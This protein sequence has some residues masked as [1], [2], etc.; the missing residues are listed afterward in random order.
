MQ[1]QSKIFVCWFAAVFSLA[2]VLLISINYWA[3]RANVFHART[4]A[5]ER[6]AAVLLSN[7]SLGMARNIDDRLVQREYVNRAEPLP[8]AISVGSSR[9]REISSSVVPAGFRFFNHG[10]NGGGMEDVVAILG[11]YMQRQRL[12]DLVIWSVDPW[13]FN[14]EFAAQ[15]W[16]SIAD[17]YEFA[18]KKI[19]LDPKRQSLAERMKDLGYRGEV[20]VRMDFAFESIK[21]LFSGNGPQQILSQKV[22]AVDGEKWNRLLVFSDG[23][24]RWGPAVLQRTAEEVARYGREAAG[25]RLLKSINDFHNLDK[26]ALEAFEKIIAFLRS[27]GVRVV[28]FL[29][30]YQPDAYAIISTSNWYDGVSR[31]EGWLRRFARKENLTIFGSFDPERARC[32]KD[33]FVDAHHPRR[34]CVNRILHNLRQSLGT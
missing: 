34:R 32:G 14:P 1:A 12:P 3:D 28:I 11:L 15:G 22:R 4:A 2:L 25:K 20:L 16:N 21:D 27:N 5:A 13:I 26:N 29:P 23:S 10:V 6:A 19:G 31:V 30:P 17:V 24:F 8:N 18:A 7:R 9:S 33:D